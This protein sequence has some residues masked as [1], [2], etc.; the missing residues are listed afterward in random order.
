[1]VSLRWVDRVED[2]G[3]IEKDWRELQARSSNINV[4]QTFEWVE[5]WWKHFGAGRDA[6]VLFAWND[7]KPLLALPLEAGSR[8]LA[9]MAVKRLSLLGADRLATCHE[10]LFA[11]PSAGRIHE[12][13]DA[14]FE[15]I[16]GW[17]YLELKK[18]PQESPLIEELRLLAGR[19]DLQLVEIPYKKYPYVT[20]TGDFESF[21]ESPDRRSLKRNLRKYARRLEREGHVRVLFPTDGE[22]D[23]SIEDLVRLSRRGWKYSSGLDPFHAAPNRDYFRELLP[24][25]HKRKMLSLTMLELG[26]EKIAAVLCFSLRGRMY[27]YYKTFDDAHR[28]LS[29]DRVTLAHTIERAFSQRMCEMDFSEGEEDFKLQWTR[30]SLPYSEVY[31]LNRR[32]PRLPL[33]LLWLSL[34]K[35]AKSSPILRDWIPWLRRR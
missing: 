29:P 2:M 8:K 3:E 20:L 33:L 19:H 34:R 14:V 30:A 16:P 18:I 15:G 21:M 12:C 24:L 13:F 28:K 27:G 26:G 7:R 6:R 31:M 10:P 35:R 11:E 25:F 32:S 5:T 4:F 22:L 1:M 17:D 23:G 9:G